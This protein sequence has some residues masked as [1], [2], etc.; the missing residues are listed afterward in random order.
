LKVL[1]FDKVGGFNLNLDRSN[2]GDAAAA[3]AAA[4]A[5]TIRTVF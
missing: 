4:G 1:N 3:A 2:I 5:G